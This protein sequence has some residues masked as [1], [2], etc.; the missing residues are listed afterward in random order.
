MRRA[1]GYYSFAHEMGHNMGARH[2]WFVDDASLFYTYNHGYVNSID[3]WRTIMA[4]IDECSSQGFGCTRVQYWSNPGVLLGG[5][6]MGV[7]AGTSATCTAG[8]LNP[9][10]DADNHLIL[11]SSA[12]TV[13]NF[14]D[15]SSCSGEIFSDGFESGGADAWSST[16]P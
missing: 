6:P 1:T 11:D 9:V 10:C 7:P 2:D 15:S 14:R 3:R 12:L 16:L 13:A 5:D 8:V 4:Y